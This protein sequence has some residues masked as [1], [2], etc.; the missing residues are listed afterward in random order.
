V[1]T[2]CVH[3]RAGPLDYLTIIDNRAEIYA[4]VQPANAFGCLE[5]VERFFWVA[6]F[7]ILA[8]Y[9]RV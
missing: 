6:S 4:L 3:H 2:K 7:E 8:D 5:P 9:V 1:H